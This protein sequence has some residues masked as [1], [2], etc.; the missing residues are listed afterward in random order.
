MMK[1]STLVVVRLSREL[2]SDWG[3]GNGLLIGYISGF[4]D[5]QCDITI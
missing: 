2:T 4:H 1:T 3:A 5:I